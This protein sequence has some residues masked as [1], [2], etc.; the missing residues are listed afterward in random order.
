MFK[1][2]QPLYFHKCTRFKEII[3]IHTKKG[4]THLRERT[5]LIVFSK[6]Y[7]NYRT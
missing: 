3:T 1:L 2:A 7:S 6:V 5:F 4:A